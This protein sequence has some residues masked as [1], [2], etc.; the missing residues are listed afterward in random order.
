M[1]LISLGFESDEETPIAI[2]IVDIIEKGNAG[3]RTKDELGRS[4]N[5]WTKK[6]FLCVKTNINIPDGFSIGK[7]KAYGYGIFHLLEKEEAKSS[8]T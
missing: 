2:Q 8:L 4:V 3:F 6:Y 7:N 5:K 1:A